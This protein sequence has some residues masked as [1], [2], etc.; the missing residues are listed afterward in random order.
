MKFKS[1]TR[2]RALEYEK[3]IAKRWERD[4]TFERSVEQ[5]PESNKWVFYDGPPFLTGTPHHGHLLV[6]T[7]K[8]AMGRFHTMKGQRV[9]RTWGWDC[10]GLPAEVYVEKQLGI[11]S[12]KEIG[13]K[14]SVEDYV[15][16]CRAA[17]VKTGTEWED[18]IE[19][20][21]RWVE[22]RGA[23]K[24]MDKEYM[25]SVWWAFKTLYEK[26]K[27]YEGE[28]ILVYCTKDATP[29]SKSEVAM[30]NS[31]QVDTDPSVF[32]YFKLQDA[33][34]YL[35]AWTTT[36]WTLPANVAAAVHKDEEYSLLEHDGK[37]FYV[38]TDA[39]SRVMQD[40]KKQ[41][42]QY[43]VVKKIQ[44]SELVGKKY[45]PLF[46]NRGP[47][48]HQVLHADFVTTVDGTGIVHEA[49]AYGEEDYE[50]CKAHGIPVV[51]IVD[52]DGNYTEG[53]WQGQ[54]IWEVNKLIAKTLVEEGR[55]LKVDYIQHE[56]PHCHRCGT[57][58]MYRAHPSWFM[59]IQGQKHEMLQ[60]N[61]E[62]RWVPDVLRTG[63]FNN[64]IDQAPDWNLSRDRYWATPI[65]VW[66][67]VRND[68]TEE[69]KVF[70]SYE[71][72][73]QYTG[74]S[75]DD[76]HLPQVMNVTFEMDGVT[77]RHIGKVLDCWFESGSM[78]FA[79]FHYPFENKAKFES[80]YPADFIIEA[81]D[82]TRGWFYSLLAVNVGLFDKAPWKNLICTGFINAADGK[83]MSKK[84][85]NYTDP[86]ELMDKYSADS[87][88]F[89]M[90]NSP[91]T[92]GE[93]FALADKDVA[94]V[95]RK[96]SM[97]WNMYDFFTMYAE[98]DNFSFP[99]S[100]SRADAFL[101]HGMSHTA[102]TDTPASLHSNKNQKFLV[103]VVLD[104]LQN[105]LDR[106][107][108]S[109]L[110]QL[111]A[112]VEERTEAYD[113]Q[114]ALKPILPFLDDASNWYVRRSRR[115]FWKSEDDTDKA[116]AY[117]TLHY[118]LTRLSYLLAP[119]TPFMAD[120]LHNKL[121][122][123]ESVHLQDW[124]P[125]GSVDSQV[126]ADM[127]RARQVIEQGLA[128]R[129]QKSDSEE[130]VKVRQPL[131]TL[132]YGGPKLNAFYEAMIADE[133]NVKEV[134]NE[135]QVKESEV[136][137]DK[138]ITPELKRE[139]MMREVV[140]VVQSARKQ[141]GL[142]VDDHISLVLK[143]DDTMLSQAIDDFKTTIFKETLTDK[144]AIV[145]DMFTTTSTIDGAE[146]AIALAKV[147]D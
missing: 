24:T 91:L 127:S 96:L 47:S 42:L 84:L 32:V 69:V 63:R 116:D 71:E 83:K 6:S 79:Q 22:F 136:L 59:D 113:L 122:G 66:K 146:I 126:L 90:L 45:E 130:Q 132:V 1:G 4:N 147:S 80:S 18:T 33:D 57:K 92:N 131:A 117:K 55:A 61:A 97:V 114:G 28:K 31:Y 76:Y 10:H 44:G 35:L 34:E 105:P 112:E 135:S 109:R 38:A 81:I 65:P 102:H 140:R 123:G 21:G 100:A 20:L 12:K 53:H 120:E 46:E 11:A 74:L 29:I 64:I 2:R 70:G 37:K 19:R 49:P 121:V 30:E 89:L 58:L 128:A 17:M 15:K 108:V 50:L 104:R 118:V 111:V 129:M 16:A 87:F 145:K 94:D 138:S 107:I 99:Y 119:F 125:A 98:V 48:A 78:S 95:A 137:L 67:G 26:G 27:I 62:T 142:Q 40:T 139:G 110:H 52:A 36:P 115:R 144:D 85:K 133:V 143:T 86:M 39:V 75:L 101:V 124:L 141:A 13:T 5:R 9:E 25:E 14:I 51:S 54:N 3:D 88:R 56:Y 8:D 43:N 60:A 134:K 41:P 77:M 106:W 23:Y 7:V 103:E 72:F 82:Q 73:A 68:G 93:N